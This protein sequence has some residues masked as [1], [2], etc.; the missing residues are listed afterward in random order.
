M[1][2]SNQYASKSC[3]K[4]GCQKS[5]YAR[6]LCKSHY[7]LLKRHGRPLN[8]QELKVAHRKVNDATVSE[9]SVILR[10]GSKEV[11]LDANRQLVRL[12]FRGKWSIG[13]NGYVMRDH[14]YLHHLV[15]RNRDGKYVDHINR[16]KLDCRDSN[17]RLVSPL[18]NAWNFTPTGASGHR[19]VFPDK[20]TGRWRVQVG[21][22]SFGRF[23]DLDEA[24]SVAAEAR[25]QLYGDEFA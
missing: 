17:L 8:S 6:S 5:S 2:Y 14:Q 10:V 18:E 4:R 7:E 1:K 3:L 19:G 15:M 23:E 13:A 9:G 12:L 24:A 21:R 20:Q 16:N 25:R 11:L 22:K